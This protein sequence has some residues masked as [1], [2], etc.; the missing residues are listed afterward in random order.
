[1]QHE[2][3]LHL[4]HLYL[5]IFL[6]QNREESTEI[7]A[8]SELIAWLLHFGQSC[9]IHNTK[10]SF[11]SVLQNVPLNPSCDGQGLSC[12]KGDWFTWQSHKLLFSA[13]SEKALK[14]V[15]NH[16]R[17][18]LSSLCLCCTTEITFATEESAAHCADIMVDVILERIRVLV[19]FLCLFGIF[20][21][22]CLFVCFFKNDIVETKRANTSV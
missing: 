12:R 4:D 9:Y 16:Y 20:V 15:N 3:Y 13:T 2:C 6:E 10:V 14:P 22:C 18:W 5:P 19:A 11:C 17:P 8:K 7:G 1:M 21:G